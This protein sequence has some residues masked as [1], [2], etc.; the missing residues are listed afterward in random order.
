M[1]DSSRS[2]R[3]AKQRLILLRA[4]AVHH[5]TAGAQLASRSG[6]VIQ[7]RSVPRGGRAARGRTRRLPGTGAAAVQAHSSKRLAGHT[8]RCLAPPVR[9]QVVPASYPAPSVDPAPSVAAPSVGVCRPLTAPQARNAR[10]DR[11]WSSTGAWRRA[12]RSSCAARPCCRG[13]GPRSRS[14]SRP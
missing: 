8:P 14:T 2:R 12:S 13:R 11:A 4:S 9:C 10:R 5:S 1:P 6:L 3:H 7:R